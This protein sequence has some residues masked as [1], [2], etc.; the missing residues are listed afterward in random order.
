MTEWLEFHD[1]T[2]EAVRASD[3]HVELLLD[4]YIHRWERVNDE[5]KGTGWMR[6]VR[7]AMTRPAAVP[8]VPFLPV[9]IS[10]GDLQ[11]DAVPRH[12][13]VRFPFEA[14]GAVRLWLQLI[15]SDVVECTGSAVRI[16]GMEPARYLEDLPADMRPQ[17]LD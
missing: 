11:L 5:W 15:T 4:A 16:E 9:E 1:S 17:G 10:D 13:M 7:I 12:V 8:A 14:S 6:R 2:L 3:A